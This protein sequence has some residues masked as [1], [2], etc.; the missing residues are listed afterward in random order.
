[1]KTNES[2]KFER[3]IRNTLIVDLI[4]SFL[5]VLVLI[6]IK[7]LTHSSENFFTRSDWSYVSMILYGQTLIKLFSGIIQNMN[8][9]DSSLLILQVSCILAFG[10]IP[11]ILFLLLIEI[12]IINF[13][14]IILQFVWLAGS[15]VIY[16]IF[17]GLGLILSEKKKITESDFIKQE[18]E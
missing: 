5:P 18:D 3:K 8:E 2:L 14:I 16:F 4:F 11:S 1:M 6:A 15:I 17:G 13:V 12:G 10:L 7:L 9:K